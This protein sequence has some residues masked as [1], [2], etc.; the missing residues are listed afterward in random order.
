MPARQREH[1][2]ELADAGKRQPFPADKMKLALVA[3][4]EAFETVLDEARDA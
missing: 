2:G 3:A 1:A 4:L